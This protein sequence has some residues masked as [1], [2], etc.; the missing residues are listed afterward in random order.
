VL[1]Q[2]AFRYY[3]YLRYCERY[4][5]ADSIVCRWAKYYLSQF[6]CLIPEIWCVLCVRCFC[7]NIFQ[8]LF[9]PVR[10][11][12]VTVYGGAKCVYV[13][14]S[15]AGS[16]SQTTQNTV[17]VLA[18]KRSRVQYNRTC[19]QQTQSGD[20]GCF[21]LAY[22]TTVVLGGD[23]ASYEL[24]DEEVRPHL[25]SMVRQRTVTQ[26]P[27]RRHCYCDG[28]AGGRMVACDGCNG[29]FHLTC[30]SGKL[31]QGD[32]LCRQCK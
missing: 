1:T 9:S 13:Y 15:M 21:A 29:W 24:L 6:T 31:T 28:E 16:A 30:L 7:A 3:N 20:C 23:P 10:G 4:A 32:W 8:V 22:A 12:W 2:V 5:V 18:G 14:D 19:T 27:H 26:F 11:H 25:A 17:R